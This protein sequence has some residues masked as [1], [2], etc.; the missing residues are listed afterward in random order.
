MYSLLK[1]FRDD[2][3]KNKQTG[4]WQHFPYRPEELDHQAVLK[5]AP[6]SH[7]SAAKK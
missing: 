5:S 2:G 3:F 1:L 7:L 4:G 6:N